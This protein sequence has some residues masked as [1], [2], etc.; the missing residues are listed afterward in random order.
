MTKIYSL[1]FRC[2]CSF[3]NSFDTVYSISLLVQILVRFTPGGKYSPVPTHSVISL[4]G[5]ANDG[6]TSSN[7]KIRN[8]VRKF[9]LK[10]FQL[11]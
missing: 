10:H 8:K 2:F 3:L 4:Q 11:F 5:N 6:K 9:F 7:P 1:T